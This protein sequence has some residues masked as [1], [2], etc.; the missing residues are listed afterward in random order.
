VHPCIGPRIADAHH[1]R[2]QDRDQSIAKDIAQ[3]MFE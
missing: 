1:K 2:E 3:A